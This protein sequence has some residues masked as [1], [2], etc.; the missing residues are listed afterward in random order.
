MGFQNEPFYLSS[1]EDEQTSVAVHMLFKPTLATTSHKQKEQ[2]ARAPRGSL[3]VWG[4]LDDYGTGHT[5]ESQEE[6]LKEGVLS[7]V[8]QARPNIFG[9]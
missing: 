9:P 7:V 8:A 4:V 1:M 6:R 5:P 3:V 2:N